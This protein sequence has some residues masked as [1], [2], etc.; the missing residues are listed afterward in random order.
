MEK[1]E[2]PEVVVVKITSEAILT[3]GSKT[4]EEEL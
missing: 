2:M 1:F 3:E 4:S